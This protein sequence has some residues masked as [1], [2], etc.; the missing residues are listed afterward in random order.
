MQEGHDTAYIRREIKRVHLV[1]DR[2]TFMVHQ[3]ICRKKTDIDF[4]RVP[5]LLPSKPVLKIF[6]PV[7]ED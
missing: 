4:F 5:F 3:L 6:I 1:E 2:N 7:V